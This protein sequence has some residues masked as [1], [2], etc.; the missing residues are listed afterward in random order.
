VREKLAP[1]DIY[2]DW[3]GSPGVLRTKARELRAE[4]IA[5]ADAKLRHQIAGN[6]E[7]DR[8]K[9]AAMRESAEAGRRQRESQY[10][11]PRVSAPGAA[12]EPWMDE[13][14]DE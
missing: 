6:A 14:D 1:G 5:E 13:G 10:L 12:P 8:R 9:R 2:E 11:G 3:E 4:L 7:V